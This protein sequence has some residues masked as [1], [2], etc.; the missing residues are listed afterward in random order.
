MTGWGDPQY[1]FND[2]VAMDNYAAFFSITFLF[3]AGLTILM[4]DDY[5]TRE[6]YPVS[7][8]YPMV[9][10]A[11]A[12]AMWMASGTDMMTIFLGLEVMSICLYVLAGFFRSQVRSNEAG[13]K[14]FLLGAFSTG[15]LLYGMALI[16]G[17][18]GSTKLTEIGIYLNAHG[19]LLDNPMT[20]AGIVLL[21]IGFL[22]KIAAAPFH[23]WTPDVYEGAP[24]PVTAFMSA[25]PK[26]AAFAAFLRIM[27]YCFFSLKPEWTAML[28]ILAVLTMIVGNVI[29]IRQTNAET[30]AQRDQVALTGLDRL[31]PVEDD[32]PRGELCPLRRLVA[33]A[34]RRKGL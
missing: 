5:L 28:W 27:E 16:Y 33:F 24:T 7:E 19:S 26:A 4:S 21:S 18:T 15:F 20:L 6:G 11:T 14:Y 1:G 32:L 17:V 13:L 22:F 23:M 31:D 34:G 12:G 25:G 8:Y 29:A 3:A 9:L 2:A 10:F 30:T